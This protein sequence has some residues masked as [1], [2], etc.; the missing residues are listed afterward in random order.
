MKEIYFN[1][2]K[3]RVKGKTKRRCYL[4]IPINPSKRGRERGREKERTPPLYDGSWG[5]AECRKI[6]CSPQ[7]LDAYLM[8]TI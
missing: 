2:E 4:F 8:D 1:G 3:K 5:E 7:Q 6:K